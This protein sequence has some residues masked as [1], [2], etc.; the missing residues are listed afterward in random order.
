MDRFIA[1]FS[2]IFLS[3]LTLISQPVAALTD[4]EILPADQVFRMNAIGQS[5]QQV[6]L[7][8]QIEPG[9]H[10]YKD[11]IKVESQTPDIQLSEIQLPEGAVEHDDMFGDTRVYRNQ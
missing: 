6:K 8:W 9:Y 10:L 2:L 7:E 5:L 3:L 1:V 11:K 4:A